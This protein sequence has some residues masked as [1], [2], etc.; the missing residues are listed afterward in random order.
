MNRILLNALA[1]GGGAVALYYVI[2]D[3]R[4]W[5]VVALHGGPPLNVLGYIVSSLSIVFLRGDRR[6]PKQ[7]KDTIGGQGFLD[8]EVVEKRSGPVPAVAKWKIPQRQITGKTADNSEVLAKEFYEQAIEK[9]GLLHQPSLIEKH[10]SALFY[11]QRDPEHELI[12]RHPTD[13]SFHL[14]VHPQDAKVIME[15][16]WGELFPLPPG[17]I[18]NNGETVLLYGPRSHEDIAVFHKFLDASMALIRAQD[19]N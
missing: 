1:I 9:H 14:L 10:I 3:Y 11:N 4:A 2:K 12:H 7:I 13:G 8:P 5:K 15:T 19:N 17:W 6:N 16:N 18:R